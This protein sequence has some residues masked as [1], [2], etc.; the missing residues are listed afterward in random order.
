MVVVEE[1]IDEAGEFEYASER[2][3][4]NKNEKTTTTTRDEY[5]KVSQEEEKVEEEKKKLKKKREGE[6]EIELLCLLD[7]EKVKEELFQAPHPNGSNEGGEGQGG[8]E[9]KSLAVTRG[10]VA[11][12]T[13]AFLATSFGLYFLPKEREYFVIFRVFY[14]PLIPLIAM[15]W[16]WGLNVAVW[17]QFRMNYLKVFE[18]EDRVIL[19]CHDD[20]FKMAHISSLVVLGSSC[21]FLLCAV[22]DFQILA[23]RQAEFLY[24]VFVLL[25]LFPGDFIFGKQRR[26]LVSTLVRIA[27]PFSREVS[28]ADFLLAD[29]LTSLAR[30]IA[31]TAV[32]GCRIASSYTSVGVRFKHASEACN[33]HSWLYSIVLALPY[34]WRLIQCVKIYFATG[35][36]PQ[37]ANAV[38]YFTAFPVIYFSAVKYHTTREAWLSFYKPVWI[39]S[40]VLNS[41]FSFYWDIARDW[42]FQLFSFGKSKTILRNDLVYSNKE[43]YKW[44]IVTNFILR[45]T[46]T[47]KLSA[48]LRHMYGLSLV[49]SLLEI[50]RRF[51]WMFIRI[52][53]A[54]LKDLRKAYSALPK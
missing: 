10:L 21:F 51:Q 45:I 3:M 33:A 24:F 14:F 4:G 36:K 43:G 30:P 16:L 32:V 25:L 1:E 2:S 41:G 38:K 42:E 26:F 6:R 9:M 23:M 54:L 13:L 44:A 37:L 49:L 40:A 48:Q 12:E 46:W 34:L 17:T 7:S 5:W 53:V 52:E 47:C 22:F 15:L 35:E 18:V 29:V 39:V 31:D 50:F 28:F 8:R 20:V 19:P 11:F 27:I